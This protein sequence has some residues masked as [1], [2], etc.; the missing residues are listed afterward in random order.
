VFFAVVG[1][2]LGLAWVFGTAK[3]DERTLA[4]ALALPLRNPRAW[5]LTSLFALQGLCYYGFGAWLAD[6]YVEQGWSQG[7]AGG[8]VALLT[9]SAVPTSFIVPR[10]AGRIG[11][12]IGPLL[13]CTLALFAG[14][15]VL[16]AWPTLA[17]LG[18]TVVGLSLGGIFSLCLL[19]AVDL[20]RRTSQVAGFA[21]MMLGFGYAISAA[22]PIT[23]GV[24][25]DAAGS[26][27]TALWLMVTV[28]ASII[29]FLIFARHLL[30]PGEAEEPEADSSL[31]SPQ[32]ERESV[33]A[34]TP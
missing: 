20:G 22:A 5:A 1:V 34:R 9:A 11:S 24:A 13:A 10:V 17:W 33:Q 27:Q 3:S 19:L 16:A 26:F 2:L 18:S 21:G 15:L 31:P 32:W 8:L 30:T 28:A 23:L 4:P 14:S 29:V 12:R 6:A 7:T 25:R